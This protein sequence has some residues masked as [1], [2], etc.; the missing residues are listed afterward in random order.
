MALRLTM[1]PL[2]MLSVTVA[3]ASVE[4]TDFGLWPYPKHASCEMN[5]T[6]PTTSCKEAKANILRAASQMG[7]GATCGRSQA[8]NYK[9]GAPLDAS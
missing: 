8:C 7:I 3:S 5:V 9:V 4:R 1:L 6:F 2:L